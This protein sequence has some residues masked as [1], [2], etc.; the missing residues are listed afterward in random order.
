MR[1]RSGEKAR[2]YTDRVVGRHRD[3]RDPGITVV[4]ID[5]QSEGAGATGGL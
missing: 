1:D 3:H 5:G 4:A 2:F